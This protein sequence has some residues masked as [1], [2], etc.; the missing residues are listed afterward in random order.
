MKSH[1]S[2]TK[3]KSNV[4][5]KFMIYI[6]MISNIHSFRVK[7]R[8]MLTIVDATLDRRSGSPSIFLKLCLATAK[9]SLV[10]ATTPISLDE[11]I[12]KLSLD[13]GDTSL[14]M[15]N[16]SLFEFELSYT[17]L[18]YL[19]SEKMSEP[20]SRRESKSEFLVVVLP[21]RSVMSLP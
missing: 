20:M 4:L 13:L 8:V 2:K 6:R 9:E 10:L 5:K 15:P 17:S 16:G 18:A 19:A 1:I 7:K 14:V 3:S 11:G 12:P 21:P